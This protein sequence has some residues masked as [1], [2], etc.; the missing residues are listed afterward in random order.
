[1]W[2]TAKW[3]ALVLLVTLVIAVLYWAGP[4]AKARGFRWIT[5]GIVVALLI[6]LTASVGFGFYVA[7]FASCNKAYVT[8]AGVVVFLVWLWITNLADPAGP[9]VRRGDRTPA[10]R[11]ERSAARDGAL[12]RA[13]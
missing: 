9:G 6:W 13:P 12:R 1:M 10:G 2:S 5:P 8:M 4:N 7:G 3:P 11:R